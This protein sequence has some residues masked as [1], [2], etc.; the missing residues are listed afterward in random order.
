MGADVSRD[1]SS[2]REIDWKRL[3][4][5]NVKKLQ[6]LMRDHQVDAL[7][8]Q[9]LDNFQYITGY[10]VPANINL[11]P[12]LH[13][14]GAIL[15]AEGDQPI[16]LAGAA[17]IFDA[18]HFHWI[19]DVRSMPIQI[20]LWP[21]I[22]KSALDDHGITG[23][24]ALD[25]RMQHGL[26]EGIKQELGATYRFVNG[27]EMLETARAVKNDEEIKAYIRALALA[28]VQMRAA[29]DTVREGV[30]ESRVAAEAEYALRMADPDAFPAWSLF[31][32]SGDRAAYLQRS[33][34]SKIIRRGEIVMIDGGCHWNGYYSEFS[35]HV[36][37]GEPSA[38][39][40]RIYAVAFEAE[41]KAV[42]AIKPG[43][44]ASTIDKIARGII[45]D[46]GYEKY[47]HPHIT[48]HGHGLEIHDPPLIGDP[49]QVKEW[50]FE[51]G[52]IVAIEPGVFKPGVGGVREEDV[53]LVTE[54]GHEVLTRAEYENKLLSK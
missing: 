54:S 1:I 4:K 8:V 48:G 53:V 30:S 46:A 28:E 22:M 13:R 35:R 31:V 26:A 2:W 10:R 14:Q 47:Q 6:R 18:K 43:A 36:M 29:R 16:M 19:E 17:D 12:Y 52:M 32:M 45:K 24:V 3:T 23:T 44:K 41:Q 38:E 11:I 37:V 9:S 34:S 5:L 51:K 40:K 50:V 15:P 20:E 49:G 21:K 42:E 39:Q 27:S 25:S 33:P 7:I